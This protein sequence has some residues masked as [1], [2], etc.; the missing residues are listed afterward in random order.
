MVF[1]CSLF[2]ELARV[3]PT[4]IRLAVE[5]REEAATTRTK[6]KRF[7]FNEQ[8][9]KTVVLISKKNLNQKIDCLLARSARAFY[10]LIVTLR[11]SRTA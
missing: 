9:L 1:I 7:K 10:I 4:K 11:C 5:H 3:K 6:N 2:I 8:K